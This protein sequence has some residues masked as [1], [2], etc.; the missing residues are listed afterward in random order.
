MTHSKVAHLKTGIARTAAGR[1][2]RASIEALL[3]KA[4]GETLAELWRKVCPLVVDEL[5]G[6]RR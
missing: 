1:E 2:Y 5:P 6:A 4:S 3:D